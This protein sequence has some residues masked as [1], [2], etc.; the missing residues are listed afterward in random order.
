MRLKEE[1]GTSCSVIAYLLDN[2]GSNIISTDYLCNSG[3]L[4]VCASYI[5]TGRAAR[6]L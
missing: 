3:T 5:D 4:A 2:S 6:L 1:V